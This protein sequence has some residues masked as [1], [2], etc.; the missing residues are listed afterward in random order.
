MYVVCTQTNILVIKCDVNIY[1]ANKLWQDDAADIFALDLKPAAV[2][3]KDNDY[4]NVDDDF[5]I[6]QHDG[7][8]CYAMLCLADPLLSVYR[9]VCF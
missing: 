4:T 6:L 3:T 5:G 1:L 2:H 7:M 9:I 8:V